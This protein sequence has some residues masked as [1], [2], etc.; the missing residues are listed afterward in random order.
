MEDLTK[1]RAYLGPMP[2]VT[3]DSGVPVTVTLIEFE[4]FT[5]IGILSAGAF[6]LSILGRA[7][8]LPFR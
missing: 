7:I 5:E 1:V 2:M 6:G 8:W 3:S 4:D